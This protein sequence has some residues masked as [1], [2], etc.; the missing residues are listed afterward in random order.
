MRFM[1]TLTA[2]N[3]MD[4][5]VLSVAAPQIASEFSLSAVELGYLFSGFIWSY[6]ATTLLWGVALDVSA[7]G[8]RTPWA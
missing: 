3:Y 4:R 1:F 5:V 7:S 2:I 8:R 6:L